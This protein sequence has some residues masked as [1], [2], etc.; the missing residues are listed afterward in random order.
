MNEEVVQQ[1]VTDAILRIGLELGV[2]ALM[3]VLTAWLLVELNRTVR[4]PEGSTKLKFFTIIVTIVSIF[5]AFYIWLSRN[6][7]T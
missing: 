2:P 4:S 5:S 1:T 6:P 7:V 3:I